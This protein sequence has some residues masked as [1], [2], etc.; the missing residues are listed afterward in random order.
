[1]VLRVAAF[2]FDGTLAPGDAVWGFLSH[3][4]GLWASCALAVAAAPSIAA[5]WLLRQRTGAKE[6]LLCAAF[7]GVREAALAAQAEEFARSRLLRRLHPAGLATVNAHRKAGHRVVIVSASPEVLLRPVAGAL[8]VD[9]VATRLHA[10]DGVLTGKL[11][12]DNCWGPEKL[13]RL[14]D[15]VAAPFELIAAY[16]DSRGDRELLDAARTAFFRR[17]PDELSF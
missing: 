11:D 15:H 3:R 9:L 1:M 12:G 4:R 16:G 10:A 5:G 8:Q 14:E 2:D 13:R 6:A 17:F 7:A